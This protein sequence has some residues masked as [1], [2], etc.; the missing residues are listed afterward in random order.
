MASSLP[1]QIDSRRR[2]LAALRTAGELYPNDFR[3]S[4]CAAALAEQH[5]ESSRETLAASDITAALAG[6]LMTRRGNFLILLDA[7]GPIQL[8]LDRP[9]LAELPQGAGDDLAARVDDWDLGDIVGVEGRLRRSGRGDLYLQL[10]AGRLLCKAL[11]PLPGKYHGLRDTEQRFRRRHLDLIAN[12]ETTRGLFQRRAELLSA[13]RAFLDA[14]GFIEVQTPMLHRHASGAAARPFETHHNALELPLQLRIAPELHLKRLVVGGLERIYEL[15]SCFRNEGV[16]ARHNPEFT[17]LEFYRAYADHEDM[18]GLI[19]QLL[20]SLCQ[21]FF[22]APR[23]HYQGHDYDLSAPL[24]RLDLRA[25]LVERVAGLDAAGVNDVRALVAAGTAAG[26]AALPVGA[27]AGQWQLALFEALVEPS[28]ADAAVFVTGY[29]AAV[30]PLARPV[31]GDAETAERFEL[32]I[33]G[34]EL[35]NGFSELNDPQL[36]AERFAAQAATRAAGDVLAMA[37]DPDYIEALE[38]GLPP[39]AGAGIGVDRLAMLL[40]DVASIR[41]VLLFPLLRPESPEAAGD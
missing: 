41:E 27:G 36:Q 16:S 15:A 40:C 6:R 13:L 30:S 31:D 2:K 35:A 39:T 21:R 17:M 34:M 12:A 10:D 14:D 19:E 26:C 20:R 25:A 3:P 8:Y 28:L 11:R 38:T 22:G 37:G 24:A 9:A 23:L 1:E 29:P 33:G 32:F 7:S 4:E 18:M 5:A